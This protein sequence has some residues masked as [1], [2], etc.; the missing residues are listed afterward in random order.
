MSKDHTINTFVITFNKLKDLM[1]Y[2]MAQINSEYV[3]CDHTFKLAS[4]VGIYRDGKWIPQYDSLFIMQNEKS[5]V[6]FWQLTKGTAY[7]SVCDGLDSIRQR[8]DASKKLKGIVID[9][10]CMW[11]HKLVATFGD[12]DV[13]LDLFHAVK[14]VTTALS[15]KHQ[16]TYT[17]LQD[18]QLVFRASGD[19]GIQRTQPTPK[20]DTLIKT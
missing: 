8:A 17:A 12:I 16:Y 14:R 18:F 9:N 19:N 10:C 11:K 13:K 3:S 4:H 2:E 6:I 5:Q 15:K 1:F 20:S 7:S